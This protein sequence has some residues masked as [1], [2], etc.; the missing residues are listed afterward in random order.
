MCLCGF[1]YELAYGGVCETS[2]TLNYVGYKYP[3]KAFFMLYRNGLPTTTIVIE[4]SAPSMDEYILGVKR[5]R[6]E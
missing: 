1:Y 2:V 5:H 3:V 4:M 6:R